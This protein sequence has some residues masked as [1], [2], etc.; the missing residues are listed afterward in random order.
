LFDFGLV[1]GHGQVQGRQIKDLAAFVAKHG[2]AGQGHAAALAAA[3]VLERMHVAVVGLFDRLQG[4]ARMARLAAGLAPGFSA[5]V[6]GSRFG[7]AIAGGRLVAVA[8][9][10]R[11]PIFQLA[12][13]GLQVCDLLFGNQQLVHH[14]LRLA[15]GLAQQFLAAS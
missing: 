1:L 15:A 14:H 7:Q 2:L 8:A 3:T 4:V 6:F 5:Q 13:L 11:L 12:D 9:V 10:A